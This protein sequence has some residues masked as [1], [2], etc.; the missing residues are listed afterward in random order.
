MLAS[1]EVKNKF[2]QVTNMVLRGEDVVVTQYGTP[3][4]MI[5]PYDVGTEALRLYR[6]KQ[7]KAFMQ[8]METSNEADQLSFDDINK[9]VH[10]LRD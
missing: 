8:N 1:G 5:L 6:A 3:T 4:L 2:G 7:M 9:M 10:D